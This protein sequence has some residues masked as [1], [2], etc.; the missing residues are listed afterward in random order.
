MEVI[1]DALIEAIEFAAFLIRQDAISAEGRQQ[2]CCE[3][4]VYFFEQFEE[5]HTNRVALAHQSVTTRLRN[6]LDQSFGP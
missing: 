6:A 1:A 4:R 2:S 3:R 5:G